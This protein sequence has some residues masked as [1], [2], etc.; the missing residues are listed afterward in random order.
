MTDD[1]KS[2]FARMLGQVAENEAGE[3]DCPKCRADRNMLPEAKIAH[4]REAEAHYRAG[5]SRF[6]VGDLVSPKASATLRG[7]GSPHI[8]VALRDDAAPDFNDKGVGHPGYGRIPDM[9][10]LYLR[11][12]NVVPVWVE[13]WEF[14][15]YQLPEITPDFAEVE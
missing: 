4:L 15:P 7:A 2:A 5:V 8:V 3:C 10:V 6:A 14:E 9:R 1:L 13:S 11:G 12:D